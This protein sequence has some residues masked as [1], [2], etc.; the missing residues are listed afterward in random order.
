MAQLD[1]FSQEHLDLIE[2]LALARIPH[3]S[4]QIIKTQLFEIVEIARK[5]RYNHDT[6]QQEIKPTYGSSV[7]DSVDE[8]PLTELLKRLEDTPIPNKRFKFAMGSLEYEGENVY[9]SKFLEDCLDPDS[10]DDE[11]PIQ[12]GEVI[13]HDNGTNLSRYFEATLLFFLFVFLAVVFYRSSVLTL[14]T[15]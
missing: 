1:L 9:I 14:I 6:K 10:F 4:E 12:I 11:P 13:R 2:N 3:E 5:S 7:A 15:V 8:P